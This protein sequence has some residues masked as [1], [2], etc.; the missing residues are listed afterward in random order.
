MDDVAKK[1]I[2]NMTESLVFSMNRGDKFVYQDGLLGV[3]TQFMSIQNKALMNMLPTSVGGSK[4]TEGYK[5]RLAIGNALMFGA[6]GLGLNELADLLMNKAKLPPWMRDGIE[7]G[8]ME[9]VMNDA[10]GTDLSI[11]KNIAPTSEVVTSMTKFIGAAIT[12]DK[13]LWEIPAATHTFNRFNNIFKMFKE[14]NKAGELFD[15][16]NMDMYLKEVSKMA[17][18]L[19]NFYASEAMWNTRH[20]V[21]KYGNE[22]DKRRFVEAATA[23]A[24]LLGVTDKE[25]EDKWVARKVGTDY[26]A[27]LNEDAKDFFGYL[28]LKANSNS[29]T[30]AEEFMLSIRV[31]T[32][33][34]PTGQRM[35]FTKELWK[36]IVLNDKA[37]VGE[38]ILDII[39]KQAQ[40]GLDGEVGMGQ[41]NKWYS[42][43]HIEEEQYT[44]LKKQFNIIGQ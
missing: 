14:A 13:A 2:N 42:K 10:L 34:M 26:K 33:R 16:N 3:V 9:V 37:V 29:S 43:G 25:S 5:L 28:S 31:R 20:V 12:G 24:K 38:S 15:Q 36:Q 1:E 8:M 17:S 32:E 23:A 19:K 6:G 7:G 27:T 22:T 41:I 4:F 35:A 18:G 40:F 39:I 44:Y 30:V 11:S 21:D